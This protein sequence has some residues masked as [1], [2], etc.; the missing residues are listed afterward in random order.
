[1]F[2]PSVVWTRP[3]SSNIAFLS[4]GHIVTGSVQIPSTAFTSGPG[5]EVPYIDGWT[6]LSNGDYGVY[7]LGD[8]EIDDGT[9][10]QWTVAESS[11]INGSLGVFPNDNVNF[12]LQQTPG[13]ALDSPG[14]WYYD[15]AT[16]VLRV[17]SNAV[18]NTAT[19]GFFFKEYDLVQT[20]YS[21]DYEQGRV[22]FSEEP[23]D[24]VIQY[25]VAPYRLSYTPGRHIGDFTVNAQSIEVRSTALL[26]ETSVYVFYDRV[27]ID[28]T[29]ED[30]VN[31]YS[32]VVESINLGLA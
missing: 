30:L 31:Y 6:E 1:E 29:I 13:D 22:F 17:H 20:Q 18:L 24:F 32:P 27:L 26:P 4:H 28:N 10:M 14:D 7:T 25:Q 11:A 3:S 5:V 8:P 2:F 23:E 21:V 12:I 16:G 15:D 19:L 9:F